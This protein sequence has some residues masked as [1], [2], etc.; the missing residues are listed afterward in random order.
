MDEKT[1]SNDEKRAILNRLKRIEGQ[2][3]GIHKMVEEEASCKEILM[4]IAA[5]RSAMNSVGGV[6]IENYSKKCLVGGE[7]AP[8]TDD[9]DELLKSILTFVK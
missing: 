2:V 3:K 9:L 6:V 5:V 7:G 4:Q 8:C 1:K